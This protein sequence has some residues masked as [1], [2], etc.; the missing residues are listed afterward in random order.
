[1]RT[2]PA[3]PQTPVVPRVRFPWQSKPSPPKPKTYTLRTRLAEIAPAASARIEA[4]FTA[5]KAAWPPAELAIIAIKDERFLE[6]HARPKRGQWTMIHRYRVLGASGG[7][8]PKLEQGD[9]QVPEGVYGI[10]YLNPNSA[11]HLSLRVNYPNRFDRQMAANDGRKNLGGDIMIHGKN[12]SAGCLAIGDEA[13]EEL[14]YLV[15][16][17]GQ[18]KVK[19][20][21]APTDFRRKAVPDKEPGRPEWLP[22]LYTQVASEM[23][24]FEP[25]QAIITSSTSS[26]HSI[27]SSVL[28]FFTK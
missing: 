25:P 27:A 11:F 1:L 17:T 12:L 4:K 2:E 8:G 24:G 15:A 18:S 19:V 3:R 26:T 7:P 14:F 22:A 10:S 21:I 13:V 28:S 20:I 5:A 6:L 9:K 23:A 16:R